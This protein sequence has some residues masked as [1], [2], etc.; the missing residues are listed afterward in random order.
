MGRQTRRYGGVP[1]LHTVLYRWSAR[2]SSVFSASAIV[3]NV[4]W[5][6]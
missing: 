1:T 4:Q 5:N 6:L 3:P 2:A